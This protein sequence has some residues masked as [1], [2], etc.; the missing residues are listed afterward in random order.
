MQCSQFVSDWE[1]TVQNGIL[2]LVEL[3]IDLIAARLSYPPVPIKL[4]E[5][6]S[7]LFDYNNNFQRRHRTKPYDRSL[8]DRSLGDRILANPPS[9]STFSVY[10]RSETCGWLCQIINRFVLRDG[11]INLKKQFRSGQSLT[12]LVRH[13]FLHYST[14]VFGPYDLFQT[15]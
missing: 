10:S 15:T 9:G 14:K 3:L 8:Y 4:L 12:V 1:S 2:N 13:K 5:V 7:M 6:L 11:I